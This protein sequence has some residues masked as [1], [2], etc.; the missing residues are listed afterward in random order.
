VIPVFFAKEDGKVSALAV[1]AVATGG[2][3][4]D[5]VLMVG[6]DLVNNKMTGMEAVAHSET[7]GLGARIEEP[8]F[9]RQWRG[10]PIDRPAALT[11]DGGTIDAISG[12]STTAQAAV[13][14]TNT[15]LDFVRN[16]R[17]QILRRIEAL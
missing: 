13:D 15:A 11:L 6:I 9:R 8:G 2:Y 16:N 12:A 10:L 17:Q 3:G 5:L 7:P 1:E 14:G 4:G